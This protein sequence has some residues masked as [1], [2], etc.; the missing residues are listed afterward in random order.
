MVNN[1]WIELPV[2][3]TTVFPKEIRN[4]AKKVGVDPAEIAK[5]KEVKAG[6]IIK[7]WIKRE[8]IMNVFRICES[9]DDE[10]MSILLLISGE[11]MI[12]DM[13]HRKLMN[14]LHKFL[15]KEPQYNFEHGGEVMVVPINENG[16][17]EF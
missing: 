3:N 11:E 5:S 4:I 13:P 15:L 14:K 10:N 1:E 6:C 8:D 12:V 7:E 17:P 9:P 2:F 16:M